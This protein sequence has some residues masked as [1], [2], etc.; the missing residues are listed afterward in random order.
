[1]LRASGL[2]KN[3]M[4]KAVRSSKTSVMVVFNAAERNKNNFKEVQNKTNGEIYAIL[5]QND[6][7]TRAP[8]KIQTGNTFI[9]N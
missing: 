9:K 6:A 8:M 3:A 2:S 1:M 4:A 5:F 7:K